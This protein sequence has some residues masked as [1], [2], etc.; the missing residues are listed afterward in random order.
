MLL[1]YVP[2]WCACGLTGAWLQVRSWA[3]PPLV[4]VKDPRGVSPPTSLACNMNPQ[5][6][7]EPVL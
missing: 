4:T 5:N 2:V 6:G 3:F 7:V 1:A